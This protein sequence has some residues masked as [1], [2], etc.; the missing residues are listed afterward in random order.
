VLEPFDQ[1]AM[2]RIRW[3]QILNDLGVSHLSAGFTNLRRAQVAGAS[4]RLPDR[5][6]DRATASCGSENHRAA[7]RR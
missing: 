5:C 3:A 4:R 2:V 1:R 6:E 7:Q